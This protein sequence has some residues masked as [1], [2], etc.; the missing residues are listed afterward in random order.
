MGVFLA[1]VR[2]ELGIAFNALTG[3]VV[4]AITPPLVWTCRTCWYV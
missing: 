3:Y 4:V 1:L 2:R